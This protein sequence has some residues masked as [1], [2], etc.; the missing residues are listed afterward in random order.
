MAAILDHTL[1]QTLLPD[2]RGPG[3]EA[4]VTAFWARQSSKNLSESFQAY[5]L[6]YKNQCQ[7]EIQSDHSAKSLRDIEKIVAHINQNPTVPKDELR[8]SLNA[9]Y[10]HFSD[11]ADH[12]SNSIELAVR[13]WLMVNI[14]TLSTSKAINLDTSLSWPESASISDV[15]RSYFLGPTS[16]HGWLRTKQRFSRLL[17]VHNLEKIGG[18]HIEWTDNLIDHLRLRN[19]DAVCLYYHVEILRRMKGVVSRWDTLPYALAIPYPP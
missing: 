4:I 19:N 3:L 18:F 14:R 2:S 6:Y 10:Q 7:F 9:K 11:N 5:L 8:R 16:R 15:A 1:E 13:L 12:M 17:T